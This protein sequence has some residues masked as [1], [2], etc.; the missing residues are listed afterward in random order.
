VSFIAVACLC[1]EGGASRH[2]DGAATI[3]SSNDD[4]VTPG[5]QSQNDH[6]AEMN[7]QCNP[8]I[9]VAMAPWAIANL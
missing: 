4:R 6:G 2:P 3:A 1:A 5:L 8:S 7:M 9:I